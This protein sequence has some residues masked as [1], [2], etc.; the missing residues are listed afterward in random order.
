[1]TD[2]QIELLGGAVLGQVFRRMSEANKERMAERRQRHE[3]L[4]AERGAAMK[5]RDSARA[6]QGGTWMR[7]IIAFMIVALLTY[8]LYLAAWG[9]AS[10]QVG[11]LVEKR[12]GILQG[13]F[14]GAEQKLKFHELKGLL[15]HPEHWTAFRA[16]IGFY[17][18]QAVK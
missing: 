14:G 10:I 16:M 6:M 11:E 13:L 12:H 8:G 17:F 18:G 2:A 3:Y 9:D 5:D 15:I 4:M 1:M 7:R